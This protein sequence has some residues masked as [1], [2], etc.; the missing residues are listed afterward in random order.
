MPGYYHLCLMLRKYRLKGWEWVNRVPVKPGIFVLVHSKAGDFYMSHPERCSIAKKFFWTEGE[1]D[2]LEDKVAL[3]LF[4]DLSACSDVV[5]DIGANSGLFS[6]VAAKSNPL[7]KVVALDILPE[8]CRIL[9]DNLILNNLLGIIEVQ[10]TA[11]GPKGGI[12]YAPFNNISS[13]MPTSLSLDYKE[14]G[15][16]RIQVP[17]KTLDEICVPNF[18][19][20]KLSIKIDVEGTEVDIFKYGRDTLNLIK[21]DIVCE[22][23]PR[24]RE[25][26]LYDKIL[27]E[28][29]YRKYLITS[30]GLK[31]FDRVKPD[32]RYKDWFFT[33]KDSF[34]FKTDGLS[35]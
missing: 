14:A 34:D 1:R 24:T 6:L 28:Y 7:A 13:E 31:K 16:F 22:V 19:A 29:S 20:K 3:D 32:A 33:T 21:P 12:F 4:A 2:P 30:R 18:I 25:I 26:D 15:G 9:V 17:V 35:E 27:D 5:L 8:A 11:V 23:I 10:L